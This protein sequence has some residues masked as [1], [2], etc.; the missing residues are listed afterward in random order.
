MEWVALIGV[1]REVLGPAIKKWM[2][3][4]LEEKLQEAALALPPVASYA[5]EADATDA[6]FDEAIRSLWFWQVNR[7]RALEAMK[8]AAREP[9]GTVRRRALDAAELSQARAMGVA[10][11]NE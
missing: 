10:C 3:S 4:C 6:L 8:K 11:R 9:D 2:E 7:R 1:L 5:C